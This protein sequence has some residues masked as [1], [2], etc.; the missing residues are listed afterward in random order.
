[1]VFT[2]KDMEEA[3]VNGFNEGMY[4]TAI[5]VVLMVVFIGFIWLACKLTVGI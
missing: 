5:V 3:R 2:T 4:S 1:M